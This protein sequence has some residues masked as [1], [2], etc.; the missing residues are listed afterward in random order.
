M[1]IALRNGLI[2][3]ALAV[4]VWLVPGG[5]TG[6][7]VVGAVL[8][9]L[10]TVVFVVFLARVYRERRMEI[11]GLGDRMRGLLYGSLAVIVFAMA[12]RPALFDTAGGTFLWVVLMA[13]AVYGVYLV[14][15]HWRAWTF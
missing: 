4:V 15:R 12:A 8:N 13:G 9:T 14:Y 11:F 7:A 10:I 2:V 3:V 5:G 6:A 1:P